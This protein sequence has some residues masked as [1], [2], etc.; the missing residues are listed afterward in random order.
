MIKLSYFRYFCLSTTL[1]FFGKIVLTLFVLK[2]VLVKAVT[3]Q[4]VPKFINITELSGITFQHNSGSFGQKYLPETMGPG[5]AFIDYNNDGRQDILLV[6]GKDWP[7]HA[8]NRR[9]IMALYRNDG[10]PDG[11]GIPQFSDQTSAARLDQ[12]HYGLGLAVADYDNDGDDD[13][14]LSC[15]QDDRLFQNQGDG[16][17]M[18]KQKPQAS[19][20]PVLVL[21]VRGSTTMVMVTSTFLWLTMWIGQLRQISSVH[22]MEPIN[23]TARQNH[24]TVNRANYFGTEETELFLILVES[25]VS[26]IRLA[27]LLEYAFLIVTQT[28]GLIFLKPTILN[29]ISFTKIIGMVRLLNRG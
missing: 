27:S 28:V 12:P 25:L 3:G 6:N 2:I 10:D 22:S 8:T 23:P 29:Q 21:V 5:C 17:F 26:R 24:M 20:I 13:F 7:N 16:T 14:Y 4:E 19:K 1:Q 11:N 15:L 9:Q 18:I